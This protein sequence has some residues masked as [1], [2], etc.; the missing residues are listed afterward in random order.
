MDCCDFSRHLHGDRCVC[1]DYS[2]LFRW[3]HDGCD[4]FLW[5]QFGRALS[6][7]RI[8]ITD[9]DPVVVGVRPG[10]D[11]DRNYRRS[12]YL[13][14]GTWIRRAG[15]TLNREMGLVPRG[16]SRTIYAYRIH[17]DKAR[18]IRNQTTL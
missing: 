16:L 18:V 12:R 13:R 2:I 3:R 5:H 11:L 10:N 8:E 6:R 17:R 14:S 9:Y 1:S 4:Y 15:L 7:R